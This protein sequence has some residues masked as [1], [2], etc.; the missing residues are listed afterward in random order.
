[1]KMTILYKEFKRPEV[2][3]AAHNW[4]SLR[5]AW[6]WNR[7]LFLKKVQRHHLS[8]TWGK[9]LDSFSTEGFPGFTVRPMFPKVALA[10]APAIR[11]C[12]RWHSAT[13]TYP[14]PQDRY[15]EH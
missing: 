5:K 7:R 10:A 14:V 1:M 11:R 12:R 2:P 4:S 3:A 15:G 13:L 9:W 8:K 6:Y